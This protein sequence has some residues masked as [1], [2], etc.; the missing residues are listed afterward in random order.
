MIWAAY[1][2]FSMAND[3]LVWI[4]CAWDIGGGGGGGGGDVMS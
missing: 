3:G 2:T 1:I 4:L